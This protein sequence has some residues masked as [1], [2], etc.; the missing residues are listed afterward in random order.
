MIV[1]VSGVLNRTV[2]DI[3]NLCS[4]HRQSQM[5]CITPVDG[6]KFWLLTWLVN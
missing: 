2:V 4:G 5:N 3:D 6:I 1:R